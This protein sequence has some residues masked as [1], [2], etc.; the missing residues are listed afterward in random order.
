MKRLAA[1]L[2]LAVLASS[3]L[4]VE[5]GKPFEQLDLDRALPNLPER[6]PSRVA[7]PAAGSAPY[8]Q[9]AVDGEPNIPERR[10]MFAAASG[11]T[12]SDREI[13]TEVSEATET[14]G[15]SGWATGPWANDWNFIAPAP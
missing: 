14:A 13:A 15:K 5:I 8:G 10:A 12:R 11:N 1:A 4:A 2:S 6:A 7:D 9:P 3:A